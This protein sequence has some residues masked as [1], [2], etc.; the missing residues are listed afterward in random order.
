LQ[1]IQAVAP[2]GVVDQIME[3]GDHELAGAI[4][5]VDGG[6]PW[7]FIT[8]AHAS[9]VGRVQTGVLEL[10]KQVPGGDDKGLGL[11]WIERRREVGPIGREVSVW[12]LLIA[13][14]SRGT[15]NLPLWA[16]LNGELGD[17][18]H[19]CMIQHRAVGPVV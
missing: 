18:I 5:W 14:G 6:W 17:V 9:V 11:L 1:G 7:H 12:M 10:T 3:V 8:A 2:V 4:G 15:V 13:R 16:R 19:G